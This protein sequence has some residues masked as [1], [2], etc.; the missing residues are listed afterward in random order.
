M[1]I[2][3]WSS[4]VCSADRVSDVIG[5]ARWVFR[6]CEFGRLSRAVLEAEAVVSGLQDVAVVGEPIEECGG[7]L[8]VTE[9]AGPLTE[10]EVGGDDDAGALVEFAQQM[11]EQRSEEHTSELQSL[12]R[13]SYAVLRLKKKRP[14]TYH[15]AHSLHRR[16]AQMY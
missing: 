16:H 2:S 15:T 14:H 11:E 3:G 13:I 10:A 1:R 9:H 5:G 7:H 12:M 4:D 6:L 8:R